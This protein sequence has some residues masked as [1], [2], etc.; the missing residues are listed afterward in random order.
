MLDIVVTHYR[1]AWEIGEKL[2]RIIGLQRCINFDDV[3]VKVV[4][5]GGNRLPEDKLAELPYSVEQID[6]PHGGVSAARNA[7]IE[8]ATGR[9]IMFCDFDDSFASI[10]SLREIMTLLK[11]DDYDMLWC[12]IIAE[13]YMDGKQLLYY[14]PDKQRY[15]FCHGKVYRTAFLKEKNVRFREDLVFNEDSC[16]NAVIIARTPASR[17]GEIRSPV[18]LYCW[19]RR[20]SSVTNSGREDEAAYGHFRRNLIVTSEYEDTGDE[21]LPGM[22]T[23]T[24]YDTFYMIH[25]KRNGMQMKRRIQDEFTPWI[26]DRLDVYGKVDDATLDEIK[27]IAALELLELGERI[28]D[29]HEQIAKWVAEIVSI[30]RAARNKEAK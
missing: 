11:T 1:E 10:F 15:V 25:G 21:R 6:I 22:V 20:P 18:P 4:N 8:H 27:R 9:W 5:D 30:Y 13:D 7:G 29:S 12:R 19:I 2:F 24:A 17:I 3:H 28:P 16:F 26:S 23:R 14:V